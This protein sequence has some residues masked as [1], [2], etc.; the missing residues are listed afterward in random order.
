MNRQ[1]FPPRWNLE[2]RVAHVAQTLDCEDDYNMR[3]VIRNALAYM[4]PR[5]F[6]GVLGDTLKI[7]GTGR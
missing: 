2:R 6:R 7:V 3:R 5:D 4:A 1:I